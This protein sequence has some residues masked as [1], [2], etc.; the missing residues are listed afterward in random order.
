MSVN[1]SRLVDQADTDEAI[2]NARLR[3]TKSAITVRSVTFPANA[4][5]FNYMCGSPV[6]PVSLTSGTSFALDAGQLL[7]GIVTLK[8]TAN[9]ALTFDTAA[10]IVA[11]INAISA[12]A[13]VGDIFQVLVING[14]AANTVAPTA[15][16]GVTF[17]ANQANTTI[18]AN[19]SRMFL[20]RLTNVTPGAEAVVVYW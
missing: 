12:G 6:A 7:V 1:I 9:I 16:G 13:Q 17:D 20:F 5:G 8:P 2:N 4:L 10:Q 18:A 15:G 14:A 3:A 11:G 19:T